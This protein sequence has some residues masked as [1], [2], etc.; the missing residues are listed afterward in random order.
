VWPA[1]AGAIERRSMTRATIKRFFTFLSSVKVFE[2]ERLYQ[3]LRKAESHYY[4]RD[5]KTQYEIGVE[6]D[7]LGGEAGIIGGYYQSSYLSKTGRKPQAL[8]MLADAVASNS[9]Y[10]EKAKL[11][12]SSIRHREGD[13]DEAIRLRLDGTMGES[14]HV[15][16]ESKIGMSQSLGT[17]GRHQ[18]AI[19]HLE[20]ALPLV[21]KLGP[22]PLYFD[23]LNSFAVELA[24]V[25]K[26]DEAAR[27]IRPVVESP[28]SLYYPNW[29]ET[30]KDI[31]ERRDRKAMV[32]IE[33]PSEDAS[34][35]PVA[36]GG[37][38]AGA[39]DGPMARVI[40]FPGPKDAPALE[41]KAAPQGQVATTAAAAGPLEELALVETAV[42]AGE[43]SV[44][45]EGGPDAADDF[46]YQRFLA[47]KF[48][49]REKV[50]DWIHGVTQ[51]E[52]LG[53]FMVVLAEC[54]NPLE[55][56]MILEQAIDVIFSH[57]EDSA[58]AKSRWRKKILSRVKP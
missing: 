52:D 30:E 26:T 3:L 46:P 14:L 33:R 22:H 4:L 7:R 5:Y 57:T 36:T 10:S 28:Y 2:Q 27:I 58:R 21:E 12:L 47:D 31:A 9:V 45:G 44:D 23:I 18:E 39:F 50:E 34:T 38:E 15:V 17:L 49:L 37:E 20:S 19:A 55:R 24:E 51:P 29:I 56:E 6:L 32:L 40:A 43:G 11:R 53:T 8:E 41:T 25:G 48:D 54:R 42:I 16:I 1:Y 13:F 35:N